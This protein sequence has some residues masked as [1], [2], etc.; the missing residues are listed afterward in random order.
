MSNIDQDGNIDQPPAKCNQ[1]S[2]D[3][4]G[5]SLVTEMT[6]KYATLG[7]AKVSGRIHAKSHGPINPAQVLRHPQGELNVSR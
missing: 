2:I 5:T 1:M 7:W 6:C 4:Q 3:T